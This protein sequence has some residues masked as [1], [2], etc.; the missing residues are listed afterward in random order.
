MWPYKHTGHVMWKS[1]PVLEQ[2]MISYVGTEGG[3]FF[4][5]SL[6]LQL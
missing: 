5:C 4:N 1:Q 3:V 2:V 6:R